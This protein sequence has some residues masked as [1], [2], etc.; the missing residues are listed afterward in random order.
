MR[1]RVQGSKKI[2]RHSTECRAILSIHLQRGADDPP[3][4][5]PVHHRTHQ[6]RAPGPQQ[7]HRTSRFSWIGRR[8]AYQQ[9][10]GDASDQVMGVGGF[11]ERGGIDEDM[12]VEPADG[13]Q[14][15][16]DVRPGEKLA[17]IGQR[18]AGG[19]ES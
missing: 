2:A 1:S 13:G 9:Y 15:A 8:D 11:Q 3:R 19:E 4:L 5:R 14:V 16:A 7:F 6:F 10:A 12:V 17:R 18:G